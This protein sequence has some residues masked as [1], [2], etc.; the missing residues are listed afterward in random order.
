MQKYILSALL[1]LHIG[2]PH[3]QNADD[4]IALFH[5]YAQKHPVEKIYLHVD[6]PYYAAGELMYMRAYLTDAHLDTSTVSRIIYVELSDSEKRLVKRSLLYSDKNEFAGQ[7]QLPDSLPS[8]N[9]HLRAY[10][11]WMRN[12]GEDYL[13]H[14]DIFIGNDSVKASVAENIF[15][16][17]VS[18]FPEGGHLI[19]DTENRVAFKSLGNDGF[20]SDVSCVLKDNT[21]SEILNFTSTHLGMGRF[22]FI[23]K[24]G[25]TYQVVTV[26]SG[27]EKVSILP[28]V[29]DDR[30]TLSVSQTEDSIYLTIKSARLISD[31]VYI[32]GQSRQTVCYAL[33]GVLKSKEESIVVSKEKFPTGIAQFTLFRNQIPESER[34]IF[35]D[36]NN[37]LNI[38]IIPDK[39]KY[40]DRE[41]AELAVQVKD[42]EGKPVQGSFSLS[43]TD[44][45]VVM[46]SVDRFNIKSS[47]LLESDLKGFIENPGWY[48][49]NEEKERKEALDILLSTQ[50]WSRFSW[51]TVRTNDSNPVYPMEEE[52]RI[53]GR[54]INALGK[55]VRGGTVLLFSNVKTDLPE[56]AVTDK[57]G[58]FGFAGF[59]N[60]DT[61][62]LVLQGRTKRDR[63]TLLD[64]Q[65]DEWDNKSELLTVPLT[66]IQSS[67]S[68]YVGPTTEFIEQ[69]IL[70]NKYAESIWTINLPEV[71]VI[72]KKLEQVNQDIIQ[73]NMFS[74]KISLD[75][76]GENM[77]LRNVFG[78]AGIYVGITSAQKREDNMFYSSDGIWIVDGVEVP[79][80]SIDGM[81][82]AP[83][84]FIE[85]VEI[86]E[87]TGRSLWGSRGAVGPI[88]IIK[89]K[90]PFDI[91][92]SF[93][94]ST[95]GLIQH[96]PEGYC[97]YKKFYVPEY[98]NPDIRQSATPDLRTT[99]YWN[100]VIKTDSEGKAIVEF[101][102]ADN[103]RTYS[104]VM[105]GIGDNSVGYS[106]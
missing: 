77:T 73:Q 49:A 95:P 17:S 81:M 4:Y 5:E 88:V 104:Y 47:L 70:Q 33:R 103:V 86:V 42:K 13:F 74:R 80:S 38:Q 65:L 18:F 84:S 43:V 53:T 52:F 90:S 25:H 27:I 3:S 61:T 87:R 106:F 24:A 75:R 72:D 1:F 40:N 67:M 29:T 78:L 10:T 48:F 37:D 97:I 7:I 6:K 62:V 11:N 50:G 46:P 93:E 83:A 92:A 34:L 68:Q 12:A 23:P 31:S 99:I 8:S 36:R 89:T 58:R 44:D 66:R 16:Y 69:A 94:A 100:P 64:I 28:K 9:Y 54:L 101:F 56:S 98:D 32:I 20:G 45:K 59:N 60:P 63:R 102:T 105:E 57:D 39:E 41:K 96:K 21:G 79:R 35:I 85:S 55:P 22:S 26:S 2:F 15:D 14:R 82:N 76:L 91:M 51:E 30:H 19:A 71:E